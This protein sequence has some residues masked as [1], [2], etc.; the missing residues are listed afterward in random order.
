MQPHQ[1]ST[2]VD[3]TVDE[4]TKIAADILYKEFQRIQAKS[5]ATDDWFFRFLSIAVIPFFG[6]LGYCAVTPGYRILV[7]AL[8]V[9]SIVGLLVVAV[10]SSHYLYATVYGKYLQREINKLV[11]I[12]IMR[13][14]LFG[15]AAY[16]R[17]TPVRVSY[18]IGLALLIM[19]NL[20]AGPFIDRELRRFHASHRQSL[21]PVAS[22]IDQYWL[23]VAGF[24]SVTLVAAIGSFVATHRRL[25]TLVETYVAEQLPP[26]A[27]AIV[28][29]DYGPAADP[30]SIDSQRDP[31]LIPSRRRRRRSRRN[32]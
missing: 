19:V 16:D 8:P 20:L 7:A 28:P 14:A 29:I 15:A 9:L 32:R 10:L 2:K 27:S 3:V 31:P 4:R 5:I 13:D 21:G 6:F 1:T 12:N 25:R 26:G 17:F 18:G 30:A 11:R 22:L 23:F 24:L